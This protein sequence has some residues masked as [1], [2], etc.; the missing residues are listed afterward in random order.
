MM[1]SDENSILFLLYSL[2]LSLLFFCAIQLSGTHSSVSSS[3][4]DYLKAYEEDMG[5]KKRRSLKKLLNR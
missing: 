4:D 2:F 1:I 5:E 3:Y